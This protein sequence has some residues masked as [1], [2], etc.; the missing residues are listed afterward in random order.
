MR[1]K[2]IL[3]LVVAI[4]FSLSAQAAEEPSR[5]E[6]D[7]NFFLLEEVLPH[8]AVGGGWTTTL[9][10][11][12]VGEQAGTFPLK[13]YLPDGSPWVVSPTGMGPSSEFTITLAPGRFVEI[14]L[15]DNSPNITT[16]WAEIQQP[17]DLSGGGTDIGGQAIFTDTSPTEPD[18]PDFEAVV[19]LSSFADSAFF[20]PFDNTGG[21]TTCAA[22]ANPSELI[23]NTV[24]L[25]YRDENDNSLLL[26][27]L[28]LGPKNQTAFCFPDSSPQ[29]D[30]RKGLLSVTSSGL[31][32]SALAFRFHPGGAFTT[33]FPMS[34]L[35]RISHQLTVEARDRPA[36][37]SLRLLTVLNVLFKYASAR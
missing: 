2:I 14:E 13:F 10:F 22:F 34:C 3:L 21:F 30:G 7:L 4:R 29:L 8:I 28:V 17:R 31:E 1:N 27:T 12:D 15:P 36:I 23:T 19:P 11:V 24:T 26:D 33:F 18:R 35:A 16:G 9:T 5:G 37:T 20:L 25:D 32:L 6:R